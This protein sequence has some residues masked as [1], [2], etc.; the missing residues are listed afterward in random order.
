MTVP[1]T[2]STPSEGDGPKEGMLRNHCENPVDE[3]TGN[4]KAGEGL[5]KNQGSQRRRQTRRE[6]ERKKGVQGDGEGGLKGKNV[7]A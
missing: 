3:G 7:C 1:T 5:F 6:R 4:E 2:T